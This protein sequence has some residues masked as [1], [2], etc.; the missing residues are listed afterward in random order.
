MG[1]R[2]LADMPSLFVDALKNKKKGFISD[3]LEA[4]LVFIF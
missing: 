3:P 4:G 2:N 1:W